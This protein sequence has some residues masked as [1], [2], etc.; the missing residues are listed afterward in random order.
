MKPPPKP[1][2]D[3]GGPMIPDGVKRAVRK[4]TD[5]GVGIELSLWCGI[6]V[7]RDLHYVEARIGVVTLYL[8]SRRVHRM[9]ALLGNILSKARGRS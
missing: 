1:P 3:L 6:G 9:V 4:A 8:T 5:C 7:M 2:L